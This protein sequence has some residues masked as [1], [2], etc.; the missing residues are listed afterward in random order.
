MVKGLGYALEAIVAMLTIL[1]FSLGALQIS[2]PDQDWSNYQREVAAHDLTYS[3]EATGHT[4]AFMKRS[5]TGSLQTS[6]TTISDRDMEV[7]GLL[8]QLP[9]NELR[10]GYYTLIDDRKSQTLSTVDSGDPCEGDLDELEDFSSDP[11]I[12]TEGNLES[13]HNVTLYFGNTNSTS[14]TQR[15][16]Y[17]ALWVDNGTECQ[18]GADEGPYYLDEIFFWGDKDTSF[19]NDYYDFKSIEWDG[20]SGSSEFYNA[21]QPVNLTNSM[22]PGP[23]GIKTDISMDM[24]DV[25]GLES[26][27]FDIAV[28]RENDALGEVV[29]DYDLMQ[30]LVQEG[31]VMFMMDL[32]QNDITNYD[33]LDNTGIS[34]MDLGYQGGYSGGETDAAFSTESDSIKVD[35]YYTGL[36]G[37]DS[38]KMSPPGKVIS[39]TSED[40]RPSRTIYSNTER[41]DSSDWQRNDTDMTNITDHPDK[42]D[43]Q[44]YS[45]FDDSSEYPLSEGEIDFPN[46]NT[47]G[48]LSAKLGSNN[49]ACNNL[50]ERGLKFDFND[51]G[52]YESDLYL[53]GENVEISGIEYFIEANK[54]P[55]TNS[56][57]S[58]WGDCANFIPSIR[59]SGDFVELMIT[60][61]RFQDMSGN[62][63]ALT[64][65][66]NP[67]SE[68]QNKAIASTMFWLAQT[69]Q[70]FEGTEDPSNIDSRSFGSIDGSAYLPYNLDLRWS[71]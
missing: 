28:F 46:G 11:I 56:G 52:D 24:V 6:M 23:N 4:E 47:V 16:G 20:G 32:Q 37:S 8:S 64:G 41:Y 54:D 53:N 19:R 62:R 40:L 57:C 66:Q 33:F 65:Y 59:D 42:P 18:F 10:V 25:S 1:L 36:E 45:N 44:C 63:F 9:V 39:N 27:T 22:M 34:W 69:E 29:G 50:I 30:D 31:S 49:Q 15:A 60:R 68:D 2:G 38:F 17:D 5:E 48:V 35:T 21:T 26:E 14:S 43:S 55:N 61:D 51:D 70:T 67:Y 12:K 7:S 71:D 58:H 3:M 13:V